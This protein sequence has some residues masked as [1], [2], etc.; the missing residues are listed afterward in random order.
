MRCFLKMVLILLLIVGVILWV[1]DINFS[2]LPKWLR[3]EQVGME[4]NI[5]NLQDKRIEFDG[6]LNYKVIGNLLIVLRVPRCSFYENNSWH[7]S[8]LDQKQYWI[9]DMVTK[10]HFGDYSQQEI[11]EV[12]K[13]KFLLQNKVYLD[14]KSTI[15][16]DENVI[17]N[18]LC[19][20][21]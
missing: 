4:R 13:S 18:P 9:F 11:N 15:Y 5:V 16:V 10:E 12:L 1:L 21:K 3:Y 17:R 8:F 20:V 19:K 2:G 6:V 14:F 7:S